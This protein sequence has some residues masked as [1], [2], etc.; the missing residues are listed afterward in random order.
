MIYS[1]NEGIKP[2][3]LLTSTI[4]YATKMDATCTWIG[5]VKN[6]KQCFL[7]CRRQKGGYGM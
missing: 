5:I 6:V 4:K 2:E 1:E 7:S 3:N